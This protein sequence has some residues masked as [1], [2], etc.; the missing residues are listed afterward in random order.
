MKF[1]TIFERIFANRTIIPRMT[2]S[3]EL[4]DLTGQGLETKTA[5]G[6]SGWL[7]SLGCIQIKRGLFDKNGHRGLLAIREADGEQDAGAVGG[8]RETA[9]SVQQFGRFDLE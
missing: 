3:T 1:D 6:K 5:T 8:Y 7:F 4:F 9:A 2:S